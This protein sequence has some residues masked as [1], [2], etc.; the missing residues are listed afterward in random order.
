M[1]RATAAL[2]WLLSTWLGASAQA[3][4]EQPP[5]SV[6]ELEIHSVVAG[7]RA[8]TGRAWLEREGGQEGP[9]EV[10]VVAGV[11]PELKLEPGTWNLRVDIPGYWGFLQGLNVRPGDPRRSWDIALWPL[12][13]VAGEVVLAEPKGQ[14]PKSVEAEFHPPPHQPLTAEAPIGRAK[15]DVDAGGRVACELPAARLDLAIRAPGFVPVYRWGFEVPAKGRPT[16]G[17]LVL[18]RGASLSGFVVWESGAAIGEAWVS[19]EPYAGPGCDPQGVGQRLRGTARRTRVDGRGFFQV[20]DLAPGLYRVRAEQV[21]LVPA[22]SSPLEVRAQEEAR[23]LEPLELRRPTALELTLAPA[24]DWRGEPWRIKVSQGE[25]SAPEFDGTVPASGSITVRGRAPGEYW[26][27]VWDSI[28]TQFHA[29]LQPQ[30]IAPGG[31]QRELELQVVHVEGEIRRGKR[32]FAGRLYFGGRLGAQHALFE[33]DEDGRFA[34]VL[35]RAGDWAVEVEDGEGGPWGR[36]WAS[37]EAD[38]HGQASVSLHVPGTEVFGRVVDE[39]G[40][41]LEGARVLA[42]VPSAPRAAVSDRE[43]RFAVRGFEPGLVP[44]GAE[45]TRPGEHWFGE[46]LLVDVTEDRAA[47]PYELRLAKGRQLRGRLL[48]EDGAAAAGV[49]VTVSSRPASAFS[50]AGTRTDEEGFYEVV[51]PLNASSVLVE[52]ATRGYPLQAFERAAGPGAAEHILTGRGGTLVLRLPKPASQLGPVGPFP[53]LFHDGLA[54]G[55][56]GLVPYLAQTGQPVP[57][58]DFEELRVREVAPGEYKACLARLA[59][60]QQYFYLGENQPVGRCVAGRLEAGGELEL[61]LVLP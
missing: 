10:P 11:A 30:E 55:Y 7:G 34:G 17:R 35:P 3:P 45:L 5:A 51:I 53:L 39:S 58:D 20:A 19:I 18:R 32:P 50:R 52:V 16:V 38:R 61:R 9:R 15:C 40:R 25:G 59:E 43:G 56:A 2:P 36:L 47:G 54:L 24:V 42:R 28:G 23:L 21:G 13:R 12:A 1:L 46:G 48:R 22:G 14:M 41:P 31:S 60:L 44:L 49:A 8:L 37:V 27:T 29:D 6:V 26:L 33:A 4:G 57:G